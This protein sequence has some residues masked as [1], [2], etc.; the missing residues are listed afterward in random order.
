M[1]KVEVIEIPVRY[2]G[3]TYQAGEVF[4]IDGKDILG[5]QQHITVISEDKP[6]EEMKLEELKEYAKS[7]EINLGDATKKEDILAIILESQK[8]AVGE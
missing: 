8:V 4:E 1:K 6:I 7:K 3:E 5:I 2:N